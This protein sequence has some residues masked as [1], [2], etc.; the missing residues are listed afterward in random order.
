ME[1]SPETRTLSDYL[2]AIKARRWLVIGTTLAAIA[3]SILFSIARTP[4]YE[5]TATISVRFDYNQ[6]QSQSQASTQGAAGREAAAA[7]TRP[8]VLVAASR[9]LGDR[10]PEQLQSD[11]TA[12]AETDV[13]AVSIKAKADTADDAARIANAVAVAA[14]RVSYNETV[15]V[16]DLAAKSLSD[17]AQARAYRSQAKIAQPMRLGSAAAP[18]SSPTSPRPLRDAAFAAL[19]GLLLGVAIALVRDALDRT[20]TDPDDLESAL[21]FPLLGYVRSD[22]LGTAPASQ[23]GT[24]EAAEHLDSFRILRANTQFLGGDRP[25]ATLAVTSPLP[26][27]GK[28]TVALLVRIRER[29]RWQADDPDRVRPPPTRSRRWPSIWILRRV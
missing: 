23:N 18:P 29:P 26:D 4:V 25:V 27:E 7:V 11:V 9:V 16:L 8:A 24:I 20:V 17:P 12:T 5:A 10:T 14:V 2:R 15:R 19:L 6:S 3:A 21:G 28:S 1:R 22:I 13:N